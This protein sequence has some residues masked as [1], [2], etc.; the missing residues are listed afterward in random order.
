[1]GY[2]TVGCGE[3]A[4]ASVTASSAAGT[5]STTVVAAQS[6]S[7]T[8][9]INFTTGSIETMQTQAS[10]SSTTKQVGPPT[11]PLSILA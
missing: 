4:A 2:V 9:A 5:A 10:Y 6:N 7:V 8:F 11:P 1:V 3:A